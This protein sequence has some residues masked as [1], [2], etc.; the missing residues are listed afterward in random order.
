MFV[1]H[2][3]FTFWGDFFLYSST[4]DEQTSYFISYNISCYCLLFSL[5]SAEIRNSISL[6]CLH[7]V[8]VP[9]LC[10]ISPGQSQSSEQKQRKRQSLMSS[11]VTKAEQTE[12]FSPVNVT[13]TRLIVT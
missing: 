13:N 11:M 10:H 6:V 3:S 1:L 12:N 4:F 9:A 2:L 7:G 5:K 8:V